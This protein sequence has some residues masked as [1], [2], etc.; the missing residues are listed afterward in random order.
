M[1]KL[2][3]ILWFI[4]IICF[5]QEWEPHGYPQDFYD[6]IRFRKPFILNKNDTC[7]IFIVNDTIYM[8][9]NSLDS[10]AV[11]VGSIDLSNYPDR[12]ELGDSINSVK[13]YT[14]NEIYNIDTIRDDLDVLGTFRAG[15]PFYINMKP[16]VSHDTAF[17]II[18]DTN[19]ILFIQRNACDNL[20]TNQTVGQWVWQVGEVT[21]QAIALF[22]V[23]Y[24]NT[25]GNNGA[26]IYLRM[27][28]S[29][30]GTLRNRWRI[31]D[32]GYMR[33]GQHIT[34]DATEQLQVDGNILTIGD[35]YTDG[36]FVDNIGSK[37]SDSIIVDSIIYFN[38]SIGIKVKTFSFSVDMDLNYSDANVGI[39][40]ITNNCT[41]EAIN[42][43]PGVPVL[44]WLK[45]SGGNYT[46][47]LSNMTQMEGNTTITLQESDGAKDLMQ[48]I[49]DPW[50]GTIDYTIIN[51]YTP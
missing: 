27:R 20:N 22:N 26:F 33:I 31:S 38:N 41:I 51:K 6:T 32:N 39:L 42:L 35:N 37:D 47:T 16:G 30:T 43:P 11:G 8:K 49:L 25:G 7:E 18:S 3:T 12:I 29:S 46:V 17:F 15:T 21:P 36:L 28:Q 13:N 9:C 24:E 48:L 2:L 45:W 1:K 4:N 40:T 34:S 50:D 10:V 19:G 23:A 14:D 5:S 44:L